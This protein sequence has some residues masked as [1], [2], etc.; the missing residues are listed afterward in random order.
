M[1]RFDLGGQLSC[2]S[3]GRGLLIRSACRG[4]RSAHEGRRGDGGKERVRAVSRGSLEN[5]NPNW[6]GEV[7]TGWTFSPP[8]PQKGY[9]A[10]A[11]NPDYENSTKQKIYLFDHPCCFGRKY[12]IIHLCLVLRRKEDQSWVSL[13]CIICQTQMLFFCKVYISYVYII[14]TKLNT[15]VFQ[16]VFNFKH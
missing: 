6:L 10:R 3:G 9:F 7:W 11:K 16:C 5:P 13:C 4:S 15:V 1:A 14:M 2:V 8:P 12:V